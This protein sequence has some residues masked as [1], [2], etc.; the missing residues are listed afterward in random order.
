M[1]VIPD[2]KTEEDLRMRLAANTDNF[3]A[4]PTVKLATKVMP[5][6]FLD[7]VTPER[8]RVDTDSTRHSPAQ[9]HH[10]IK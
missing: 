9:S 10:Q 4:S 3:L 7:H 2:S 6:I 8:E 1:K 5:C